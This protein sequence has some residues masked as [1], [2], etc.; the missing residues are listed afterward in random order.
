[1]N[2]A[3]DEAARSGEPVRITHDDLKRSRS[4]NTARKPPLSVWLLS[5]L[6]PVILSAL[7]A[8]ILW[9]FFKSHHAPAIIDGA[10]RPGSPAFI[11]RLNLLS[12][13]AS[14]I[15]ALA[16][17]LGVAGIWFAW[18]RGYMRQWAL[19][20]AGLTAF[21]AASVVCLLSVVY[22]LRTS[23]APRPGNFIIMAKPPR[24]DHRLASSAVIKYGERGGGAHRAAMGSGVVFHKDGDR[25]WVIAAPPP[26]ADLRDAIYVAFVNHP[27]S[28]G[29]I[30]WQGPESDA[31]LLI[32]VGIEQSPEGIASD[33]VAPVVAEMNPWSDAII[34]GEEVWIAHNLSLERGRLGRACVINRRFVSTSI[35]AYS[36]LGADLEVAPSDV[37]SGLF[38]GDGK[39]VGLL[40][41]AS[42]E[43]LWEMFRPSTPRLMD[44]DGSPED[45]AGDMEEGAQV[46]T[47]S[48]DVIRRIILA[49]GT[50]NYTQPQS[51]LSGA[52]GR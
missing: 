51:V 44:G 14:A 3:W 13:W 4:G 46:M 45:K 48:P 25:V 20:L 30:R 17:I 2:R 8:C 12:G 31:P 24:L 18:D 16:V 28:Q 9:L 27:W 19:Q 1:M 38:D 32:E 23:S 5:L 42:G 49:S 41:R 29:A 11:D 35:G 36:I 22:W 10:H 26:S 7:S 50:R 37:G 6:A 47:L 40:L 43:N 34:P 33:E 52:T 39:L 15:G 21:V